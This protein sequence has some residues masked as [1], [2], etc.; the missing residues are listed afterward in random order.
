MC[1]SFEARKGSSASFWLLRDHLLW[2]RPNGH[3]L[4]RSDGFFAKR[5]E[6]RPET[7]LG[8]NT[9]EW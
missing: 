9:L 5:I 4:F 6:G 8:R 1:Y 3:A 2:I 7:A